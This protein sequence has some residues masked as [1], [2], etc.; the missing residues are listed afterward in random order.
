M[1]GVFSWPLFW[2]QY[3][4]CFRSG[5]TPSCG[6]VW[7]TSAMS[8]QTDV[9]EA[10]FTGNK[11][12]SALSLIS[13][14][15]PIFG[16]RAYL[17]GANGPLLEMK[18]W[19]KSWQQSHMVSDNQL[20][21]LFNLWVVSLKSKL[22]LLWYWCVTVDLAYS[23]L[24]FDDTHSDNNTTGRVEQRSSSCILYTGGHCKYHLPACSRVG[25]NGLYVQGE[26]AGEN[27]ATLFTSTLSTKWTHWYIHYHWNKYLSTEIVDTYTIEKESLST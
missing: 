16:F 23:K 4:Y 27:S 1:N 26:K 8:C 2:K 25:K 3:Q 20:P 5:Q 11:G 14:I 12:V 24:L 6:K 15:S 21:L 9:V 10:I 13:K 17:I 18:C 19:S 7:H 22:Q